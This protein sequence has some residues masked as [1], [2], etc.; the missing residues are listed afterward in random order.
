MAEETSFKR[1]HREREKRK[2]SLF[3]LIISIWNRHYAD[4]QSIYEDEK[5]TKHLPALSNRK[6][7]RRKSGN[8]WTKENS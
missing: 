1:R 7:N 2:V 4:E 6:I 5:A 3:S 8:L